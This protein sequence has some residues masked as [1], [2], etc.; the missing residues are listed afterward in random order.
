MTCIPVLSTRMSSTAD[1]HKN[2]RT[3]RLTSSVNS[4]AT[5]QP[6]EKEYTETTRRSL[7]CKWT[8]AVRENPLRDRI[9]WRGRILIKAFSKNLCTGVRIIKNNMENSSGLKFLRWS[10]EKVEKKRP[11]NRGKGLLA[12]TVESR[13]ERG[14]L[15]FNI[16]TA[17]WASA[18]RC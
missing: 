1:W 8:R 12:F 3:A 2:L 18:L 4:S 16:L 14:M 6:R 13:A 11:S 17:K 15:R 7:N 5:S 9:S 10:L